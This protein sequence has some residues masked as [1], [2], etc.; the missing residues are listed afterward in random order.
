MI[1]MADL[2]I[3]PDE[4]VTLV[5]RCPHLFL[6]ECEV[7]S[8]YLAFGGRKRVFQTRSKSDCVASRLLRNST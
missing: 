2:S 1:S 4:I 3:L 8:E 5:N 7:P 6:V